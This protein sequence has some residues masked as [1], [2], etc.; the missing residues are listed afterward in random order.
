MFPQT[1]DGYN[2]P[3]T[4]LTR[5]QFFARVMSIITR[6]FPLARAAPV[7]GEFA[8]SINGIAASLEN[9]YRMCCESPAHL[10]RIVERWV[11]EI[12]RVDEGSDEITADFDQLR[13]R[14][15]PVLLPLARY[16]E[17]SDRAVIQPM[18]DE[19]LLAY[20]IDCDRSFLYVPPSRF[21]NWQVSL[22]QLHQTA[23]ENL[24]S[25]TRDIIEEISSNP[26]S[27]GFLMGVQTGDGYDAGRLLLPE[28]QQLVARR[29][30]SPFLAAVPCRDLLIC[31][32]LDPGAI[33]KLRELVK[34]IHRT[35][36]YQISTRLLLVTRDGL[37]LY[38]RG[39]P[40]L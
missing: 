38:R 19:L 20:V 6:K 17:L 32:R 3:M 30:G 14:I 10:P 33:P 15:M 35:K 11:V 12:L 16:R 40:R 22:E 9:V 37:A 5:K 2:T 4:R 7:S 24:L 21:R 18:L 31:A 13:D 23:L 36:P 1:A 28:F 8:I 25:R 39:R 26:L 34:D 27:S 29:M